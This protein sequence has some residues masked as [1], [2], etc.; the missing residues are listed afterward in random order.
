MKVQAL[1]LAASRLATKT[2]PF[3]LGRT[4]AVHNSTAGSLNVEF[5]S[6]ASGGAATTVAVPA[7]TILGVTIADNYI[8]GSAAGLTMFDGP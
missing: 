8:A 6:A 5:Y 2:T 3:A 4:V 7:G 1:P